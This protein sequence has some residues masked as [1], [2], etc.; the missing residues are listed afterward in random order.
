MVLDKKEPFVIKGRLFTPLDGGGAD[1]YLYYDDGFLVVGDGGR[2]LFVGPELPDEYAHSQVHRTRHLIFPGFVDAHVH[3][4]QLPVVASYGTSLLEWLDKYTFPEE[5]KYGDRTYAGR[6]AAQFLTLILARGVTSAAV[7]STIHQVA[8]EAL[9]ASTRDLGLNLVSGVTGMDRGAPDALSVDVA[10]FRDINEKAIETSL[11]LER[12]GYAI[13]PRF[14]ISC[15]DQMLDY[16]GQ[17]LESDQSLL[18]Q[19]HINE[20]EDE[21]LAT[22]ELFPNAADYLE[23]YDSFGLL[24]DRSL[25]AHGIHNTATEYERWALSGASVVHCPTSNTFL[26]SGLFDAEGYVSRAINVGLGSDVGGGFSLNPFVT[27][28]EAYKVAKLRGQVLD[29]LLLIYWHTLGGAKAIHQDDSIGS[30]EAGKYADFCLIDITSDEVGLEMWE[31][32]GTVQE[33]LFSL[34]FLMPD[35]K[36]RVVATFTAGVLRWQ[37]EVESGF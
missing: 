4:P 19:T 22:S 13:T 7:F 26:G 9:Q 17:L 1:E 30:L 12:F 23:V 24:S 34:M 20:T 25:F 5:I 27:M 11:G 3:Y 14:A 10:V 6:R 21:I 8:F 29:P 37:D 33:K 36:N 32:A 35:S 15:S 18:M 2:I 31:R 28:A 16:C